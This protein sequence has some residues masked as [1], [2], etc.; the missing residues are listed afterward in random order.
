MT[1]RV[2]SVSSYEEVG[3]GEGAA[4]AAVRA[5]ALGGMRLPTC[6]VVRVVERARQGLTLIPFS[7]PP[8]PCLS[9]L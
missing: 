1:W 2:L 5:L 9:S 3:A 8:E 7:A 6:Y 4:A